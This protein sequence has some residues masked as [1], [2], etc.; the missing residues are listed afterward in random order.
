MTAKEGR[1]V[2]ILD[3]FLSLIY[4]TPR[5]QNG[6]S[7]HLSTLSKAGHPTLRVVVST[8]CLLFSAC[9]ME[10]RWNSLISAA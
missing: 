9:Y 5:S 1:T 7:F 6:L 10:L 8:M 4:D 2:E 3:T